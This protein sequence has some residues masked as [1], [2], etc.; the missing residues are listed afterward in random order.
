MHDIVNLEGRG[1]AAIAVVTE[2]FRTGAEAQGKALGFDPA[3]IYVEHPIQDRTDVEMA[4]IARGALG[5]ILA[6]MI[7]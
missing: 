2:A 3:V 6:A 4:Q 5:E 7:Q 1:V